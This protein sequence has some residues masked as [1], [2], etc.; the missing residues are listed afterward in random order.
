MFDNITQNCGYEGNAGL[1]ELLLLK[2]SFFRFTV[3]PCTN[4]TGLHSAIIQENNVSDYWDWW[5]S[6]C[7]CSVHMTV[8]KGNPSKGLL[9]P[10]SQDRLG[11]F[12]RS[13]RKLRFSPFQ[14]GV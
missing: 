4:V 1:F 9:L 10:Q 14:F 13:D 5:I 2:S 11:M 3:F 8:E 7:K 12:S 6:H